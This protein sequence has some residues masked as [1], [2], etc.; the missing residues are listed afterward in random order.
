MYHRL[1]YTMFF[2]FWLR[3]YVQVNHF[4]VMSGR[5][6]RFLDIT[7]TFWEVNVNVSCSMMQH[8]DLSEDRTPD[9]SLWNPVYKNGIRIFMVLITSRGILL[10]RPCNLDPIETFLYDEKI[11]F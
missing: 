8:S 2:W 9:L 1:Y 7:S 4:L 10:I 3:I 11:C 6:N 5:S